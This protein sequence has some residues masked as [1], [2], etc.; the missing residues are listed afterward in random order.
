MSIWIL[1]DKRNQILKDDFFIYRIEYN[2]KE[3][4]FVPYFYQSHCCVLVLNCITQEI[5]HYDPMQAASSYIESEIFLKY[6]QKCKGTNILSK[7]PWKINL[8]SHGLPIQTDGCNYVLYVIKF[9]DYYSKKVHGCDSYDEST[10]ESMRP[11]LVRFIYQN[12]S[13]SGGTY[14]VC[15][16]G[17]RIRKMLYKCEI[18]GRRVHETCADYFF[19]EEI[20]KVCIYTTYKNDEHY[21]ITGLPNPLNHCWLNSSLQVLFAL[22]IFNNSCIKLLPQSS[23]ILKSLLKLRTFSQTS[24]LPVRTDHIS[25]LFK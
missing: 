8:E 13:P 18:C 4:V 14:L 11:N 5:S 3:I 22:P 16:K 10:P 12:S 7:I 9:M 23:D 2:F 25:T 15:Q 20:C 6:L 1:G 24:N 21:R 17:R 19:N